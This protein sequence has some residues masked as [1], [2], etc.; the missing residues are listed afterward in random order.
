MTYLCHVMSDD[1]LITPLLITLR[2]FV[3]S[4][5]INED[6][7]RG[8]KKAHI[9]YTRTLDREHRSSDT[10]Y[11]SLHFIAVKYRVAFSLIRHDT[12]CIISV[13]KVADHLLLAFHRPRVRFSSLSR[14][15]LSPSVCQYK[16]L[17]PTLYSTTGKYIS[18]REYYGFSS[19]KLSLHLLLHVFS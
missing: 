13:D 6:L 5:K 1:L 2:V 10:L 19:Y 15:I 17:Y 3:R 11:A 14:H 4:I 9:P 18:R 16:D 7:R 12:D 8:E